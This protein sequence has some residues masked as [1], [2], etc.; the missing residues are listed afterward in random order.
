MDGSSG[1]VLILVPGGEFEMG[2]Q[3]LDR[4]APNYD[5]HAESI[6]GPVRRVALS[7]YFISKYELTQGQ[8]ERCEG[9]NPSNLKPLS[10]YVHSLAHPVDQVS[11]WDGQ[12][13]LRRLGLAFPTEAQWEFACR[14]GTATPWWTGGEREALRGVVNIADQ[15]M[16]RAGWTQ[17][18]IADWP[19]LDDGIA[20]TAP[21]GLLPANQFGLHEVHGNLWEWCADAWGWPHPGASAGSGGVLTDPVREGPPNSARVNRGGCMGNTALQCRVTP[22]AHDHPDTRMWTLGIRP[23]RAITPARSTQ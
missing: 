12:R 5:P 3:A 15:S 11:W 4:A 8:W 20:Y 14:A 18:A 16:R 6:E 2:A 13:Y 7:P 1:I 17:S 21:V 10:V 9:R 23:A 19:D 22:R